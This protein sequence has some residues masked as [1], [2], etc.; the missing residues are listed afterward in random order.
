MEISKH[1]KSGFYFFERQ[2]LII[3]LS[4]IGFVFLQPNTFLIDASLMV[5]NATYSKRRA[6]TCQFKL[7]L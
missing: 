1:Y 6:T 5:F 2:L 3:Y 4:D 7:Y